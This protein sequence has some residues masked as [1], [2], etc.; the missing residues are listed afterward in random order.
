MFRKASAI[1]GAG[2]LI[3]GFCNPTLAQLSA[4]EI[5]RLGK[6]LTP[7]GAERAGNAAGTIPAWE[8][9]ITQPP[10]G[11]KKGDHHPDP[12]ADDQI[13]FTI[14]AANLAE[15]TDKLTAGHKAL[16]ETY[17]SFF[18]NVYPTRRS[19]AVPER[20]H[21]A[22]RRIAGTARL[23]NNGDGVA[24]AVNG[25]PFPI[26]KSGV[27]V[28]WNHLLRYRGDAAERR[29]AQAAVTRGGSYTLVQLQEEYLL[30]YS[31]EGMTE[32]ALENKILLF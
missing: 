25:I 8:G 7:L 3:L 16:L 29:I 6:D 26:P 27:E 2:L 18:M 15:H 19:A 30:L 17:P 12:Y 11:Y 20:I 13:R 22:T 24:G 9:G 4:D 14:N 21:D 31:Q 23:V 1:L 28:I 5:A 32:E 10:P